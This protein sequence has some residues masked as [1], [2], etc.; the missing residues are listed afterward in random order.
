M[1]HDPKHITVL[2]SGLSLCMMF[3]C[4]PVFSSQSNRME[5]Y[6]PVPLR[7]L[8]HFC[9]FRVFQYNTRLLFNSNHKCYLL[10]LILVNSILDLVT[11]SMLSGLRWC[12]CLE[13]LP[14][15]EACISAWTSTRILMTSVDC[16]FLQAAVLCCCVSVWCLEKPRF[17]REHR[18]RHW[19][20]VSGS[21]FS[22]VT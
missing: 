15:G 19:S 8:D 21:C 9:L 3:I 13:S 20:E 11:G 12:I 14:A 7:Y 2:M 18:Y 6:W 10:L 22:S 1:L 5:F 17:L 4:V 16:F